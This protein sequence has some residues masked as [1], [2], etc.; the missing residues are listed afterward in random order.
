MIVLHVLRDHLRDSC[1]DEQ[2]N[3][4]FLAG[5]DDRKQETIFALLKPMIRLLEVA[6]K[7]VKLLTVLVVIE[8]ELLQGQLLILF[9]AEGGIHH[10]LGIPE[11]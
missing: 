10:R 1:E 5:P 2:L 8:L 4:G 7:L 9:T 6:L 11:T 3:V